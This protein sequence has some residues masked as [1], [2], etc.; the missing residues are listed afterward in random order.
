MDIK[1]RVYDLIIIL[2]VF[3]IVSVLIFAIINKQSDVGFTEIYFQNYRDLTL[4]RLYTTQLPTEFFKNE[5]RI[6]A[7]NN[8]EYP[9]T[10]T[11]ASYERVPYNYIYIVSWENTSKTGAFTLKPGEKITVN[12]S[13]KPTAVSSYKLQSTSN[14]EWEDSYDLRW[15]SWI[16]AP[17]DI[18]MQLININY[19]QTKL[20]ED[21][22]IPITQD[23]RGLGRVLYTTIDLNDLENKP[24][25]IKKYYYESINETA[26]SHRYT[27]LNL[28]V[29]NKTLRVNYKETTFFYVPEKQRLT[30][31]II[32][33]DTNQK[34]E[35]YFWYGMK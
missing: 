10:F 5:D 11:V 28:S 27:T 4:I 13:F 33:T 25:I 2:C 6:I 34:Q 3:G 14:K 19:T 29:Q 8:E 20:T 17:I 16:D 18:K 22:N 23:L 30:V 31:T 15:R 32:N 12:S 24:Y 26:V 1:N 7:K 35:I 21:N 9:F